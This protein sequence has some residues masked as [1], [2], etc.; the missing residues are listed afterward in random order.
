[1]GVC[2]VLKLKRYAVYSCKSRKTA[3][4]RGEGNDLFFHGK[5]VPKHK[6]ENFKKRK[7]VRE[8]DRISPSLSKWLN[9][10]QPDNQELNLSRNAAAY[11]VPNPTTQRRELRRELRRS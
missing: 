10:I 1:M 6:I 2:K 4:R 9:K 5:E 8:S 7:V 3:P 11:K